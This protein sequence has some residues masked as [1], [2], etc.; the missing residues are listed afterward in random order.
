MAAS[1]SL[2]RNA[3]LI[4]ALLS[5]LFAISVLAGVGAT[6]VLAQTDTFISSSGFWSEDENWSLDALPGQGNDCALLPSPV[7][8]SN[9]GGVC[10]NFTLGSGGTLTLTP[11]YLFAYG[12]NF[13]NHGT[14]S[15]GA[16]NGL[17]FPQP[18]LT[19]TISGGGTIHLTDP[20]SILDGSENS[21]INADN[22]I[23]G[24]GFIGV[25][26]FTNQSL[27]DAN[28]SGG[29]LQ[30]H[31]GGNIGVT[32]TGTVQASNGGTLQLTPTGLGVPFNNTG[33][34]IQ[35]LNGSVVQLNAGYVITGGTLSTTGSGTFQETNVTT[36]NNLVSNAEYQLIN[37]NIT[38]LEG[39]ITNNGSFQELQGGL[40][41]A[42]NAI[43]KGTGVVTGGTGQLLAS[44]TPPATLI[45]QTTF[46]G[47]GTMGDSGLTITNQ[48]T[49]NANDVSS[50][51]ITAGNPITNSSLMEATGG[52]TLEIR[53]TVN[54]T[55]ATIEGQTGSAVLLNTGTIN[56]GTLATTGTGVINSE[57]AVLDGTVNLVTNAGLLKASGFNLNLKGAINNT[58]T[59]AL[60]KTGGCVA[61][62]APTTLTGSGK[63]TMTSANCI[64]G[65]SATNTLT[66]QS[67][68]EGGGSIGDS[69]PVGITNSGTILAN[70]TSPLTIVPDA[71]L[72]FT[73]TGKLTVNKGSVLNIAGLF[74]NF[75]GTT[76][77]AG[78]YSVTG[79]LEFQTANIATNA[80]SITLTGATAQILNSST[81]T[82]ALA[83]LAANATTG[84]LSL[85]SGQVL[86]TATN[87]SNAGK[88]TIGAGSGFSVGGSYTQTAGT[89][90]VDGTLTAPKGLILQ[91]GSLLGKGTL[92]AAVT[93]SALIT[94]GDSST[95][96]AMF[97][98]TG[99]YTQNSKAALNISI[100]GTSA[101]S[102]GQ[103]AVSN[104][105]SLGGTLS[106]K[107]I[108][109]F[110][111]TIGDTF[112][113][114]TGSALTGTFSTVK[115]TSI[116][117]SEHFDVAYNPTAVTLTVVS[118]Q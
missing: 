55:G 47:G 106:I 73:N 7:V 49:I 61:L 97:A 114:V 27:I 79:T 108:N 40:E 10:A 53:N 3:R 4:L 107:L 8:T 89:T 51:L 18:S 54:N 39:T 87:F 90:T 70:S 117:S 6:P 31:A 71:T 95:K 104:G 101:G 56:G 29:A 112:K 116:N 118:G 84:S 23:H 35:A 46:Q 43:L 30:L 62:E 22:Q 34:I 96:P 65:Y 44:N 91:K 21:V 52:G 37:G 83:G 113:V 67:T 59:I 5:N 74:N 88:T 45:N 98:V 111:P 80:A 86:T 76:L 63:V 57:N 50:N 82:S 92:A 85:Q 94:P 38:I 32:N 1:V 12:P 11:G 64:F 36:L 69:N 20:N 109:G 110:V 42:G 24:Q 78:T 19:V 68:I 26:Q 14:I 103:V 75:S 33:G 115:G 16:G 2:R 41:V 28:V 13:K 48:G 60:G 102:Y 99:S 25:A 100:G 105:V 81:N 17:Q 93:S 58:G 72:G 77:T 9:L 66:N 15:V